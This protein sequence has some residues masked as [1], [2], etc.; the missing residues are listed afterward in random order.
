VADAL[1][2]LDAENR[3]AWALYRKVVT[4]LAGDLGTG[5]VV[6]ERLTRELTQSEFD[7]TWRRLAILYHA[8]N[9]PPPRPKE[10]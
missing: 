2:D 7:D 8:L 3:E 1:A 9:P 6:L 10:T 5:G 4:R